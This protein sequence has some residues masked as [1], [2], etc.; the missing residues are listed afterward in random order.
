MAKRREVLR[1][2]GAV[3]GLIAAGGVAATGTAARAPDEEPLE[4]FPAESALDGDYRML[5][6]VAT[7]GLG[8]EESAGP[9]DMVVE[10]VEDLDRSDVEALG[11][12][13]LRS[14]G[15]RIGAAVGSFDDLEP[16]EQ[17]DSAGDWRLADDG[18]RAYAT[19]EGRLLFVGGGDGRREVAAAAVAAARGEAEDALDSVAHAATTAER[20]ADETFAYHVVVEDRRSAPSGVEDLAAFGAGFEST[21]GR[22]EG[23]S[24]HVYLLYPEDGTE[25]DDEQAREIAREIDPGRVTDAE[26]A[27][28]DGVLTVTATSEQPPDYDREAAP[29]A[30]IRSRIDHEAGTVTFEHVEGESVDAAKLELWHDGELADTQPADEFTEFA[31]GDAFAVE[32]APLASLTLRWFDEAE[33]V[34]Y[35]YEALAVGERSFE[36]DHDA[37]AE[38][39]TFTYVGERPADPE[40]LE[41]LHY[42]E[43]GR[44]DPPQFADEYDELT[45]GDALVVEDVSFGDRLT[46]RL[47]VPRAPS[48]SPRTLARVH[49]DPPRVHLHRDHERGLIAFYHDE[50]ARD[51]AEFRLLVDGEPADTQ[52]G[53]VADTL[54]RGDRIELGDPPVGSTV[55]MNWTEPDEPI[56]VAETVIAPRIHTD[57]AYDDESGELTVT[58]EEG[59]AVDAADLELRIGGE[60]DEGFADAHDEF[61]PGDEYTVAVEPF[62]MVELVWPAPGDAEHDREYGLGGTVTGRESLEADYDPDAESVEL[63]Y[64]GGQPADPGRLG[65]RVWRRRD[66]GRDVGE[67]EPLF[68]REHDTLTGGDSITIEDVAPEDRVEVLLQVEREDHHHHRHLFAY[69]PAPRHAFHFERRDGSVVAIYHGGNERDA[70]AFRVLAGGEPTD[71]QPADRHDTLTEG[72]EVVLGSFPAGTEL[73]V[74]WTAS[75]DPIEVATHTVV[76]DADFEGSYDADEGTLTVEHAGGEDVAAEHVELFVRPGR[77]EPVPWGES[78][79]ITEGDAKTFSV[80]RKPKVVH[81]VYRRQAAIDEIQFDD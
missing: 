12:S 19:A 33:N 74:E 46:L 61:G 36:T 25:V 2:S 50:Q 49:L 5:L 66:D 55:V 30:Q 27:R 53:D 60:A 13:Y 51:A 43:E 63:T 40:K 72:D 75:D 79:T 81:V 21:P 67:P 9:A 44:S 45:D 26:V 32:T 34:Q 38:R 71:V 14:A 48:H 10:S 64:V 52:P 4:L 70:D 80:D 3:L 11:V 65:V 17:T 57:F 8:D 24:E 37:D 15:Y 29:D 28:E 73:V 47:D 35:V 68:A 56:E 31:P 78:G 6:R 22:S 69:M 20:L 77:E 7:D 16:G 1:G 41:L 59:D 18:E 39:V 42:G 23:T 76:P 58:H 54:E 62:R